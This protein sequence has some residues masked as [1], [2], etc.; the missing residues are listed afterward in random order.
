VFGK[1]GPEVSIGGDDLST[2]S[3]KGAAATA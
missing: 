1:G 2:I 3:R